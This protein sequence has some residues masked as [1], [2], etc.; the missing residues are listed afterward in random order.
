MLCE[1]GQFFLLFSLDKIKCDCRFQEAWLNFIALQ[2]INYEEA[3][4]CSCP[5]HEHCQNVIADGCVLSSRKD[6]VRN[7]VVSVQ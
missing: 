4:K 5:G 3:Y 6:L 7:V 2:D 1:S